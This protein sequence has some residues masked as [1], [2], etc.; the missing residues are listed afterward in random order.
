LRLGEAVAL[1]MLALLALRTMQGW[2]C[3]IA[4]PTTWDYGPAQLAIYVDLFV[5]GAPLY[6]DFRVAPFIPLVYGPVVPAVTAKLAPMFGSGPMAALEAGR[7]LTIAS[8][9]VACA[10]IFVL[11]RRIGASLGAATAATMAFVL[12]PIVLRWGFEYRVDMQVLACELSGIVAFASGAAATAIALFVISFFIKQGNV[13][14]IATVVLFCWISGQR[15]RAITLALIWLAAV[16]AGTALLAQLYPYY[17]LNA[18]GAVRTMDLDFTAPVLF[19]IILIGGNAGLIIFAIIAVTRRRMTDRLMLCMLI[20]AAIHDLASCLRWGSNA[21]YFLLALAAV[22]IIASAGIDLALERMRAMRIIPQL[23]AGVALAVV[24]SLGFILAPRAI[25][26]SMREVLSRSIHCDVAG[27]DPWDRRALDILHSINGPVLTDAAELNLIDV[28]GNLQWIDLMVL[29]SM[30]QLG[31]FD[32]APLL[33]A[34]RQ[35]QIAAFA[36]DTDGLDRSFR[37]RALFWP[38]LRRAIEANYEAV[39]ALGPPYLMLP[40]RSR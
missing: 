33:D 15:R 7:L 39:P 23:A 9:V 25:A 6:R 1:S 2:L 17:L 4:A 16:A 29:T 20:V 35:H 14:G 31:S 40:K 28:Q 18:F 13:V 10:M 32:D 19:S 34:I 8:T 27:A 5:K 12:S 30:Q 26:M 38:R 22:T 11:A 37:G 21:Y 24:L 36:L 3:R